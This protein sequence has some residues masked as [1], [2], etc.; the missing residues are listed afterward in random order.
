MLSGSSLHC[1]NAWQVFTN[2][3][4]FVPVS[5]LTNDDI[6]FALRINVRFS[7]SFPHS[8][9]AP[10]ALTKTSSGWLLSNCT[11]LSSVRNSW[12]CAIF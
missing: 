4:W 3:P 1:R 9:I 7:A 11:S 2:K 8:A 10:T 12:N 5:K 6:P